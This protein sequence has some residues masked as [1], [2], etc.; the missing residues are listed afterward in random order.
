ML[1]MSGCA[2]HGATIGD[3]SMSKVIAESD[4]LLK[5]HGFEDV[6]TTYFGHKTRLFGINYGQSSLSGIEVKLEKPED[7]FS[8]EFQSYLRSIVDF[9]LNDV[10]VSSARFFNDS[11]LKQGCIIPGRCYMIAHTTS[12]SRDYDIM[13]ASLKLYDYTKA[14]SGNAGSTHVYKSVMKDYYANKEGYLVNI[15]MRGSVTQERAR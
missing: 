8:A 14:I 10:G 5:Q 15:P 1:L 2:M 3:T 13:D 11:S 12:L 6:K 7:Y 4:R 9:A